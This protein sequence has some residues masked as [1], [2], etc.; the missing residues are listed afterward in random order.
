M[1]RQ[2]LFA[3]RLWAAV[4]LA[5]VFAP[6]QARAQEEIYFPAVDNVRDILVSRINAE[7]VRIDMSA[8]YLTE[9]A[10]TQALLRKHAEGVPIRL[11]GDRGSIFEIDPLTKD[12][13]YIL[14]NAGVPIRLRYNPR[15]FPEIAHWKATIFVG[16]GIVSFG[17]ANYTPFELAPASSTNYKDETVLFSDDPAL[18]AAFKMKFDRIWND[19]TT[20]PESRIAAPPY[21]KNW[22]DAC[23]A[24]GTPCADYRT[25]YPN[26]APMVID[27]RRLEAD[28]PLPAEMVWGQGPSFNNRLVTEINNETRR[29][30]FVIYRLTVPNIAQALENKH[31]AGVPVRLIV[32]P[33]EYRNRKWPE[34]WLTRAYVDR[35][36]AAGVPIKRRAH[37]GLTHMKMLVTSRYATNA[38]SNYAANWQRDHNYFVPAATKPAIY[39][40]MADRFDAMWNNG[41]AFVDFYPERPDAPVLSSPAGGA[42]GVATSARLT[43]A[44]AA[45][46]TSYDV[47]LGTTSGSMTL[48][49]NVPAALVQ[50]PPTSYSWAPPSGLQPGTTYYWRVVSRT[51]ATAVDPAIAAGSAT[52]SFTTSGSAPA[53]PPAAPSSP[54]PGNGATGVSTS[55]TLTWSA[56]GATSYQVRFGTS[57]PPPSAA[58]NVATASYAPGTLADAT[59][60]YWQVVA[61]N[62]GGS[63][64]GSVWSFTTGSGSS[65]SPL[66]SPWQ[67]RDVGNVGQA[68]SATYANGQFTVRGAGADIWGS[69]DGFHFLYQSL[70]GDGV[71]TARLSSMQNTHAYA[72][73]GVMLRTSLA[74]NSA[75]VI[76][77]MVPGGG[78]EFMRRPTSGGSTAY[79]GGT[80]GTRPQWLRL[81]R[82]GDTVASFVSSDGNSWT[83]VGTTTVALGST[84]YAGVV[85][86]SHTTTT[87]NTSV[88]DQVTVSAGSGGGP[89][90]PPPPPA[91]T[92]V[93]IYASDIPA[94]ALHGAWSLGADAGSPGSV[95]LVSTDTG[96][97]ATNAPLANPAH[98]V[99]VTF[100]AE[101]GTPY[102][103]WLRLKALNDSKYNDA[104]WVQFS[105]AR[106]GG[107]PAYP[108]NSTSGLLVNL[109]TTSGADS[110]DNWGWQNGAYWLS[111]ATAVTFAS[112]GAHTMRIQ[113]R[114]DGVRLDQIVLSPS[115][116]FTSAPGGPTND[117]T[118]VSK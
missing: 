96:F 16:Q 57:N 35:L 62:A 90:P 18:V 51:N 33:N 46:A 101:A 100:N 22:D 26:P 110:L 28:A 42:T 75:H 25:R 105:D 97:A 102:R 83:P 85:V 107:S 58:T 38:S 6:A 54:S 23:A 79:L 81:S 61:V 94:A 69:S 59:R 77:D 27:T 17:S 78:I 111:Q 47:Y 118:I 45:F 71:V 10:I 1:T 92:D 49:A 2:P 88:F 87:L 106:A 3:G 109:A 108:L 24:E 50:D 9:G 70:S 30:D 7:R 41:T 98:Y 67:S 11:I 37:Q 117:S 34:F 60:Y 56:A 32:E 74:A 4:L 73:A 99:D 63:T 64:T 39:N 65:P 114:E 89:P 40:A 72:K 52:R 13:F 8:W 68:G 53:T 80:S 104:V 43:W 21:L 20:E 82:T 93:V 48:A 113:L 31:D 115:R 76:L 84:I 66:P 116:F 5:S 36:W 12:Q 91:A 95:A 14:A 15:S 19:T 55:P 86:C 112:S 103:I 44:R 29:I